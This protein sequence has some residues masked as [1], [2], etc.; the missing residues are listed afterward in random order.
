[1]VILCPKMHSPISQ[2]PYTDEN[3]TS[4]EFRRQDS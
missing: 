3:T 4:I 1:M 2:Y